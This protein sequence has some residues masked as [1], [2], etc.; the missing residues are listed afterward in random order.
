MHPHTPNW[1]WNNYVSLTT[2]RLN[3]NVDSCLYREESLGSL[4]GKLVQSTEI[5]DWS[6]HYAMCII[7]ILQHFRSQSMKDDIFCMYIV[8]ISKAIVKVCIHIDPL[9]YD[10]S[11]STLL[12]C[13]RRWFLAVKQNKTMFGDFYFLANLKY[14]NN[15]IMEF[16]I[17]PA[18]DNEIFEDILTNPNE[19][20][21]FG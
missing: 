17:T 6:A 15:V 16:I 2:W 18:I 4:S 12:L 13:S 19:L 3:K 5:S 20:T 9:Y 10:T 1:N 11:K 8:Y 21:Y 14:D 7:V